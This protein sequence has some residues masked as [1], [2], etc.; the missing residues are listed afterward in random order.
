[1]EHYNSL[2]N[3]NWHDIICKWEEK[4]FSLNE[5]MSMH[6][7]P[8]ICHEDDKIGHIFYMFFP[9]KAIAIIDKNIVK[10]L[11]DVKV[12]NWLE[13][14]DKEKI[15]FQSYRELT[16]NIVGLYAYYKTKDYSY[17]FEKDYAFCITRELHYNIQFVFIEKIGKVISQ[18]GRICDIISENNKYINSN[19]ALY[20]LVHSDTD[21]LVNAENEYSSDGCTAEKL[22]DI[23]NLEKFSLALYY[24]R[25]TQ[26]L[27][28]AEKE[29]ILSNESYAITPQISMIGVR[30][31]YKNMFLEKV[32]VPYGV[33][34]IC[35]SAFAF[36]GRLQE[37]ELPETIEIIHP[38]SFAY[39]AII[40]FII[41]DG[42]TD[43][44]KSLMPHYSNRLIEKSQYVPLEFSES[45]ESIIK[46]PL[47]YQVYN[48][49]KIGYINESGEIIIAATF[50]STIGAF[51][52]KKSIIVANDGCAWN[53]IDVNGTMTVIDI[54]G[55]PVSIH[56]NTYIK[57]ENG[58]NKQALYDL[59]F[60]K[61]IFDYGTFDF[62]GNY[63]SR[64]RVFRVKK[65]NNWGVV[66]SDGKT[67]L[68]VN[69]IKVKM[70]VDSCVYTNEK[71]I[72]KK[73]YF[74]NH[75]LY[76]PDPRQDYGDHN[77]ERDTWYA[78]TDGM[79]GDYPGDYDY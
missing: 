75:P 44:F 47:L 41:P 27:I 9:D 64:W 78:M 29:L 59:Y 14:I 6:G 19:G 17:L 49:G 74:I 58:W 76:Q 61:Y 11:L 43:K 60:K 20:Q 62:I 33:E 63:N 28:S 46:K 73:L 39:S 69:Y 48:N 3:H 37:I 24:D 22:V 67:V 1:M 52:D 15:C 26:P 25:V 35:D 7:I 57:L 38:E 68:P 79:E 71:G 65:D 8:I 36:C 10:M 66:R 40:T 30:A 72:K 12:E 42:M 5:M 2:S 32:I 70:G 50:N 34:E 56:E 18:E 53:T 23:L 54:K 51:Y 55:K 45:K 77:Y 21:I 13:V 31:F 16:T 4:N